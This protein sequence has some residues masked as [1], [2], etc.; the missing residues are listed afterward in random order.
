MIITNPIILA[1]IAGAVAYVLM[2]YM[3]KDKSSNIKKKSKKN[4]KKKKSTTDAIV[5]IPVI[6][7][8]GTWFITSAYFAEPREEILS[9]SDSV[10]DLKLENSAINNKNTKSINASQLNNPAI[11]TLQQGGNAIPYINSDDPT[12]SYNLIGSGLNIPRSE[13][14]I[15]SVLIDY[16]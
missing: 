16:Q 4:K 13:L 6:V 1:I 5:I 9:K 7:A 15:P 11:K 8:I 14:K 10:I 3:Y 2:M 12:R